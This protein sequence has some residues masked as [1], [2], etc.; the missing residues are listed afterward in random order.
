VDD[1]RD[2]NPPSNP[3]LLDALA[4]SLKKNGYRL[5]PL[6]RL[7][8]TS[9]TYALGPETNE[10]NADDEANFSHAAVKLLPAEVLLDAVG[11]ALGRPNGF[12]GLPES[13]RTA[14][15]PGVKSGETFLKT[16]GK[17]ERLLT[18]E[19]ERSESTTLA[20]AFQLI[21][22]EA[23]RSKV[24]ADDNRIGK[25]LK[26]GKSD[27]EIAEELTLAVLNRRPSA[28]ETSEIV[29]HVRKAKDRRKAWEDAAWAL[30]N[31]K[32]FLLRH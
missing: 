26:S 27:E 16:F 19:C 4:S 7:I 2:S 10:T 3:A 29:G 32:E 18:C 24:E 11:Q 6:V 15:L 8:M 17:P 21:N 31:T 9:R 12:S 1:F 20:Q 14:Q 5:R 13:L 25:F 28:S 22:G 30:I 23:I